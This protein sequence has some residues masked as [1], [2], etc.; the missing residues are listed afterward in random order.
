VAIKQWS[1]AMKRCSALLILSVLLASSVLPLGHAAAADDFSLQVTPSPLVTTLKPGI[2]T[3][4]ELKIRNAGTK[5][6]ELKIEPRSFTIQTGSERVQLGDTTP[7]DIAQWVSFGSPT[8]TVQPGQWYTQQVKISLPKEAGFSYAFAL[9]ISRKSE[10]KAAEGGRLLKGS[11]AVFTLVNVDRPGA[12]RKLETL[13]FKASRGVY[14]YLPST[15]SIKFKNT[16]NSIV[17]PYGNIFIQR[18]SK[19]KNPITTL[20]VNE[21]RGYILPGSVRTLSVDWQSGFP[22]N[23]TTTDGSGK[24]SHSTNWNWTKVSDFRIGRYTAKLVAVY[25]DGARDV[26]I[27][28][29][30]SFWVFPWKIILGILVVLALVLFALWSIVRKVIRLVKRKKTPKSPEA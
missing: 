14:E 2:P 7:S 23:K 19:D 27:E 4:L 9:L 29:E 5:P 20:P 15:L 11:I 10:P 28:G 16:G 26:P 30:V 1:A 22:L 3:Q 13:D 24:E 12:T 25:N 21:K 6:E 17:Q 8:F 18:G